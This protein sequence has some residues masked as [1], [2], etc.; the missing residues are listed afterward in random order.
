MAYTWTD[1]E[2]ITAEKLNNNNEKVFRG[3]IT[4]DNSNYDGRLINWQNATTSEV[5]STIQNQEFIK[6]HLQDHSY[7]NSIKIYTFIAHPTVYYYSTD[8]KIYCIYFEY[9]KPSHVGDDGWVSSLTQKRL[10]ILTENESCWA[11][12]GS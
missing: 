7:E 8:N 3:I 10:L 2:V 6:V 4:T 1:G 12:F 11:V 9:S 5:Y